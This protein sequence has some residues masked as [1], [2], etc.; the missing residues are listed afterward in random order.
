MVSTCMSTTSTSTSTISLPIRHASSSSS[1]DDDDD[2]DDDEGHVR[3]Y[4]P[5]FIVSPP[6]SPVPTGGDA[7]SNQTSTSSLS[8]E[9]D[10]NPRESLRDSKDDNPIIIIID[11]DD[12]NDDDMLQQLLPETALKLMCA[13]L[14]RIVAAPGD[15]PPASASASAPAAAAA[16]TTPIP[17]SPSPS[18]TP[19]TRPPDSPPHDPAP[20]PARAPA[21]PPAPTQ[22]SPSPSLTRRFNS[23]QA[24]PISIQDYALRI[25]RYCA[26]ST[27]VV[28]AASLYVHRLQLCLPLTPRNV[29]RVLLAALRVAMKKLEDGDGDRTCWTQ[30][31]FAKGWLG[32]FEGACRFS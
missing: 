1:F 17:R 25:H 26:L 21:P 30:T 3:G 10:P 11:N 9:E 20:A 29:H 19:L 12:D 23:K 18:R 24:P 5:P 6:R 15:M 2:D 22:P 13:S 8:D 14:A 28:L 32:G 31:R 4:M 16:P 27:A 7:P